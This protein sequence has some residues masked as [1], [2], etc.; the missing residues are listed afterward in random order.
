MVSSNRDFVA[1]SI[2][3]CYFC[4]ERKL[5]VKILRYI[6]ISRKEFKELEIKQ[7]YNVKCECNDYQTI[8]SVMSDK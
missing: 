8:E 5:D 6:H 3:S 4:T 1:V 2:G 7:R